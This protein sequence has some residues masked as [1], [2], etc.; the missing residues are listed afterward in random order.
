KGNI[1][2][3]RRYERRALCEDELVL[4]IET[5]RK[6]G[7]NF[8]MTGRARA[9]VYMV[10]AETGLRGNEIRTLNWDVLELESD[11]PTV[12]VRASMSKNRKEQ[13]IPLRRSTAQAIVNW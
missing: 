11:T 9:L 4:L 5:T 3:D 2:T 1:D 13:S 6:A 12:T 8:K 7:P 10:A